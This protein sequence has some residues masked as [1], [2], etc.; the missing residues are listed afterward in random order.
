MDCS[1]EQEERAAIQ[2]YDGSVPREIAEERA[3]GSEEGA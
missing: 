1:D 3:F 2:E